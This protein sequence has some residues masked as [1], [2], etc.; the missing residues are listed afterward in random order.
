MDGGDDY[1]KIE[2]AAATTS[3]LQPHWGYSNCTMLVAIQVVT[4]AKKKD[5]L[6]SLPQRGNGQ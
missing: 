3:T 6:F 2:S 5:D 1:K 4:L